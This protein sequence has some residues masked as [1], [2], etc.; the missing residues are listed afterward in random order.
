MRFRFINI[1]D[2]RPGCPSEDQV[3]EY[4]KK[5]YLYLCV[6]VNNI[7]G[8][9]I[10][11]AKKLRDFLNFITNF[12]R[13]KLWLI[14]ARKEIKK[15]ALQVYLCWHFRDFGCYDSICYLS[16]INGCSM[17]AKGK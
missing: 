5:K 12:Q 13:N 3:M 15:T 7:G 2:D 8:T 10:K 11:L 14:K 17:N 16:T 6:D 4:F 9:R 1:N